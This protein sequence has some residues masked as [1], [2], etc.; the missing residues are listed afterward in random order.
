MRSWGLWTARA[1]PHQAVYSVVCKAMLLAVQISFLTRHNGRPLGCEVGELDHALAR[2][3]VHLQLSALPHH[4]V[5]QACAFTAAQVSGD[6][7]RHA[8]SW[9]TAMGS[10]LEG[11]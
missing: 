3:H 11:R 6:G 7:S 1:K 2:I 8:A 10:V 9:G 5:H 4:P